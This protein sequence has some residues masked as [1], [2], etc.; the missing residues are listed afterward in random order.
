MAN[1]NHYDTLKVSPTATQAEIKQA[2]RRLVKLLHPDSNQKTASHE[3]IVRL[4]GAYE[5]L[6]DPQKRQSYDQG[7]HLHRGVS[8]KTS[9]ESTRKTSRQEH[10][11]N[12]HQQYR[13]QR[14]NSHNADQHLQQWLQ[15]VYRPVNQLLYRILD[16]IDR[17]VEDLSA[18]PFDDELIEDFQTY[19]N[20]CRDFLNQ[21]Q[22]AFHSL[23]NPSSVA[24]VAAHLYYCLNQVGDGIDDLEFFTLNYDEHYL[25][26]GQELFRIAA[27]LR[28]DAQVAIRE[29]F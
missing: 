20:H 27:N 1:H 11:V 17:K 19:L 23:P 24:G 16:P 3:E 10:T 29:I 26:T 21:A 22:I 9:Y 8:P 28:R 14:Q 5:I 25:H 18:D 12:V 7:L 2:Y 13:Q 4:N 15:I 6:S